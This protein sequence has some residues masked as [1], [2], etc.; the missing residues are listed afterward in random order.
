[1]A[2][3]EI[4]IADTLLNLDFK[5]SAMRFRERRAESNCDVE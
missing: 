1:M 4:S 5:W 3:L 2:S